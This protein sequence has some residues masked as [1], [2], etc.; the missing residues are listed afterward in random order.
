MKNVV[1][2]VISLGRAGGAGVEDIHLILARGYRK[3]LRH[4]AA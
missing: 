1:Q 4:D 2:L 3:I